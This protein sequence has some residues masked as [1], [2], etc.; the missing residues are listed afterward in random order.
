[1]WSNALSLGLLAIAGITAAERIPLTGISGAAGRANI[2]RNLDSRSITILKACAMSGLAEPCVELSM[3]SWGDCTNIPDAF[4]AVEGTTGL[5][6]VFME[7]VPGA[8]CMLF[9]EQF[10]G[11]NEVDPVPGVNDLPEE[12]VNKTRS[13]NCFV[14]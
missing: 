8:L 1:M 11:G 3:T 13:Y 9:D 2:S 12:W 4:D 10:C 6:S 14:F 7:D 5:A